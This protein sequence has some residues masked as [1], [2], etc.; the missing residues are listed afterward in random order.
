MEYT[1]KIYIKLKVNIDNHLIINEIESIFRHTP[2]ELI[3]KDLFIALVFYEPLDYDWH[4]KFRLLVSRN[5]HVLPIAK[6]SLDML[7]L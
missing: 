2:Y 4:C 6:I 3:I 5:N 1:S 7:F